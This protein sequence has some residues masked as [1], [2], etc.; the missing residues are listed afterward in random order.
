[1]SEFAEFNIN[2]TVRFKLT[3][4]GREVWLESR[5]ELIQRIASISS[6]PSS[7]ECKLPE[8]DADGYHSMQMWHLMEMFGG[9]TTL[10]DEPCFSTTILIDTKDLM[11]AAEVASC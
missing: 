5:R 2:N 10:G 8:P 9:H 1:M 6:R 7:I 4:R 3:P 11:V